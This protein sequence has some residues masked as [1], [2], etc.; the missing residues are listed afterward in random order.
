MSR[1]LY[2]N[3]IKDNRWKYNVNSLGTTLQ[4]N[5]LAVILGI[6]LGFLIAVIRSTYV[7]TG[8]GNI[9]IFLAKVYLTVIRGTP[10]LVQLLIIYF[11]VFASVDI[12]KFIVA[13]MSFGINSGS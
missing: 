6:A 13:V 7:L 10:V 4:I 2:L 11:V 8:K 9:L 3:F 12:N 5:L 1:Q